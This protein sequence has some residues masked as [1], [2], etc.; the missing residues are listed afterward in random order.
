VNKYRD[1]AEKDKIP[2]LKIEKEVEE[3]QIA[4]C[5]RF[6]DTRDQ[7]AARAALAGVARACE[8][9]ENIMEA[10]V[11]A[12]RKNVTLGEVSDVFRKVFGE[13]RDPAWL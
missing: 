3:A 13:H 11:E 4:A 10:C 1:A 7:S 12:V 8:G 6:R 9:D 2:T 5:K